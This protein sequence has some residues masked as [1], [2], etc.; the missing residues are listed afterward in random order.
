MHVTSV[1]TWI[2]GK[3]IIHQSTYRPIVDRKVVKNNL[4]GFGLRLLIPSYTLRSETNEEKL[5]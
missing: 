3:E 2:S 4:C 1:A 5:I